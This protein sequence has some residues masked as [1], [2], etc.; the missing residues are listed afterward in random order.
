MYLLLMVVALIVHGT[1]YPWHFDLSRSLENPLLVVLHGWPDRWD[2]H[3]TLA[4]A[5]AAVKCLSPGGAFDYSRWAE[6]RKEFETHV[7]EDWVQ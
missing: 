3:H 6:H 7:V 2:T 5:Y 4:M 1:L